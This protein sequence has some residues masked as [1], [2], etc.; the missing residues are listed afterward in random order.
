MLC[1]RCCVR[2]LLDEVF[3]GEFGVVITGHGSV[4]LLKIGWGDLY[5][6]GVK[7]SEKLEI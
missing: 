7:V 5:V 1:V 3:D 6:G 4:V 2:D